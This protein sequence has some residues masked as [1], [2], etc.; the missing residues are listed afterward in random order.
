MGLKLIPFTDSI[1]GMKVSYMISIRHIRP[2]TTGP[3]QIKEVKSTYEFASAIGHHPEVV[4]SDQSIREENM[5]KATRVFRNKL[6]LARMNLAVEY[7]V[8]KNLS[9]KEVMEYVTVDYSQ[10]NGYDI[11]DF[12]TVPYLF[13]FSDTKDQ[14]T[15]NDVVVGNGLMDYYHIRLTRIEERVR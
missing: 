9:M 1:T 6:E 8:H 14:Y 2:K 4:V 13:E 10:E 3:S 15:I 5:E 12:S 7:V 11:L